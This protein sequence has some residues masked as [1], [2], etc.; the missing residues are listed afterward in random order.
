MNSQAYTNAFN[1]VKE[2]GALNSAT[3]TAD[4]T[5]MALFWAYDRPTMGPPPV[6]FSRNLE[7]I[8]QQ[9]NNTP[10]QNARH[11]VGGA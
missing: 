2:I 1:E 6:L 3:R 4:Q 10:E 9:M 7:E 5:K 8:S 11:L